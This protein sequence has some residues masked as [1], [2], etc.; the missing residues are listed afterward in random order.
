MSTT[1]VASILIPTRGRP[2]YLDVCLRSIAPPAVVA[3]AELLVISDGGDAATRSVAERHGARVIELTGAHGANAA[4]N[5]G[6]A[7]S[8][9][10]PVVLI[11]DDVLAPAGWLPAILDGVR[12]YPDHDVFG[13]PIRADLGGRGPRSCGRE[14]PP[15]TTLDLGD[16]DC[17]AELVW[18]A[19]M[20]IRRRALARVGPFDESI[21]GRGEEEDWERRYR[22]L[23]GR[24]RYLARAGLHH[25]RSGADARLPRLSAAAYAL[26][27]TARRYDTVKSAAP[28]VAH[29]LTT[30]IGTTGHV[31]RRRCPSGLVSVAHNAGRLIESIRGGGGGGGATSVD[32][33]DDFLSGTSGQVWG[34]RA[35]S[36]ATAAD[37]VC[38]VA[39]LVTLA[40]QRVRRAARGWPRRRVLALA[41]VRDDAPNVLPA[42][43][44]EL[45]SSRH[46]VQF[47]SM[48]VGGRGKFENLD[49]LL[50]RTPLDGF[51]WLLVVDD[52]VALPGG[53]LDA[54]VFLA[55]RFDL[56]MAQPAHRWRSHAAWNVTRRR[57]F[58]IVRE[59]SF[60]EIGPLCALRS[61]TFETLLPFPPLRFGW[62][63]DAHW[64]ALARA[65][66]WRQGVVDAT[67]IQHGLRRIASSYDPTDA[68]DEGREFLSNRPYT[69]AAEA[70][71]TLVTH[72]S[73]S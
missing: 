39:S 62:G 52:D 14:K 4:R 3:G 10:D 73:W 23:G 19:N 18:S 45:L 35:T 59:T 66:G 5:A 29:E 27:R 71:R 20:V 42:A 51:D 40:P 36:R 2:E 31:I 43:R 58:S 24:I 56:A 32:S 41:V 46:E 38:D 69:A 15:I 68:V 64:S 47:E 72:R 54:F 1:P 30:L 34:I 17:D 67:P 25:R 70:N 50:E 28:S 7:A 26:G 57:P 21:Y 16:D 65:R 63:L 9:G 53:F 8:T 49:L 11:D 33:G 6:V 55:E 12:E 22:A 60:V 48:P 44:A 37:A 61:K 13:G